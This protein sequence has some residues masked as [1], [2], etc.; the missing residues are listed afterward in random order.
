METATLVIGWLFWGW[1]I[2]FSFTF[3]YTLLFCVFCRCGSVGWLFAG[4]M[5]IC[6]NIFYYISWLILPIKD[7]I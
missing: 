5:F 3:L 1:G 7:M 2:C 6:A 4:I